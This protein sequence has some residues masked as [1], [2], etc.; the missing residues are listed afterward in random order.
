[1]KTEVAT[2]CKKTLIVGLQIAGSWATPR[3]VLIK[4]KYCHGKSVIVDEKKRRGKT[5]IAPRSAAQRASSLSGGAPN[6]KRTK[7]MKRGGNPTSQ[8]A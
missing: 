5:Y 8:L 3:L 4:H 2:P 6:I 1:M 7:H